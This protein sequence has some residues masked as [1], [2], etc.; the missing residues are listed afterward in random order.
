MIP[1][2]I[3]SSYLHLRVSG[4]KGLSF[5][6]DILLAILSILSATRFIAL[7]FFLD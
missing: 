2:D 7:I 3:S 1:P 6:V 5:R 4:G